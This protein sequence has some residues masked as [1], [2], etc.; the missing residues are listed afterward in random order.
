[1]QASVANS[2][3]KY[4]SEA[5]AVIEPFSLSS[6]ASPYHPTLSPYHPTLSPDITEVLLLL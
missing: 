3:E 5:V 2:A 1:V 4:K 6:N